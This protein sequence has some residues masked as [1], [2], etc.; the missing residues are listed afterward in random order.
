MLLGGVTSLLP[1]FARDILKVGPAGL[2]LLQSGPAIG[3]VLVGFSLARFQIKRRAGAIMLWAVAGY[4]VATMVFGLSRSFP[5]SKSP[6][7][8][9]PLTN[10]ELTAVTRPRIASGVATC[11]RVW[12][13]TTLTMSKPPSATIASIDSGKLRDRPNTTVATP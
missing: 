9:E 8:F 2:G 1:I 3:A 7:R 4:G 5:L 13:T 6:S 10:T 12:R 11:T